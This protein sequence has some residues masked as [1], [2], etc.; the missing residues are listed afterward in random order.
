MAYVFCA[1]LQ[2]VPADGAHAV[3]GMP[4]TLVQ[5]MRP[6]TADWPPLQEGYHIYATLAVRWAGSA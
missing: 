6:L 5:D 1:A 4:F 2:S 3:A